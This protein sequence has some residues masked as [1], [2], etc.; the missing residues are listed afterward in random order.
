MSDPSFCES[1]LNNSA[2]ISNTS[3]APGVSGD[4]WQEAAD[5]ICTAVEARTEKTA[6]E[7]AE[8]L[9]SQ[10]MTDTQDYLR[11]NINFNL[12]SE[13]SSLEF[14][15]KKLKEREGALVKALDIFLGGD[16]RF[17]VAVGGNPIAV[18]E[19]LNSARA[20]IASAREV[21]S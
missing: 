6:R 9:Y 14:R 21:Q 5:Q 2:E 20:L 10:I 16:D 15:N 18:D 3:G 1:S 7:A 19:M 4:P 17:Q 8:A 13:I 12:S 11:S